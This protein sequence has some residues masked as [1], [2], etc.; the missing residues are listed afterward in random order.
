MISFMYRDLFR[1]Q[2]NNVIEG[3][4]F[5]AEGKTHQFT[6]GGTISRRD[7]DNPIFPS[8]GSNLSLD[9]ELS[10]GPLLPEMLIT[11]RSV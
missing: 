2:Y 9:G 11:L 1:Y 4:N 6:L 8:Q 3:Q 10:G 7:I 5:Y